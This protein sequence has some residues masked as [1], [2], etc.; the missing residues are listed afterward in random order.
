MAPRLIARP[1]RFTPARWGAPE[2]AREPEADRDLARNTENRSNILVRRIA[3]TLLG[4]RAQPPASLRP[5][6]IS[7]GRAHAVDQAASRPAKHMASQAKAPGKDR[8]ERTSV[9]KQGP[10]PGNAGMTAR[11]AAGGV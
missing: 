8:S 5:G 2:P 10:Q 1:I 3:A 7:L 9:R 6:E 4:S 11:C